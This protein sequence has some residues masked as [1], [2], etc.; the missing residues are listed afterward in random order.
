[1][2]ENQPAVMLTSAKLKIADYPLPPKKP[3]LGI[4]V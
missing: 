1:M 2:L 4:A 3:N